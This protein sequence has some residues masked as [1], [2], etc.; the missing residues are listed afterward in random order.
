MMLTIVSEITELTL[1]DLIQYIFTRLALN[2]IAV[3]CN[4]CSMRFYFYL[5][6][7]R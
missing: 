7:E 6:V 3:L 5:A 1:Y 4:L 2:P